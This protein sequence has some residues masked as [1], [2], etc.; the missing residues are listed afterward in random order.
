MVMGTVVVAVLPIGCGANQKPSL[1]L[2]L[3]MSGPMFVGA[4]ILILLCA[5]TTVEAF[6][7]IILLA[8]FILYF[9][10]LI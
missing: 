5:L 3:P 2:V 6:I 4:T 7:F 10:D 1:V 9:Y 8:Y